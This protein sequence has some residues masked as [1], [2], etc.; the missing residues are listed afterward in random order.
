[1]N[2]IAHTTHMTVGDPYTVQHI[3]ESATP[4]KALICRP[5]GLLDCM[6]VEHDGIQYAGSVDLPVG[7]RLI[8]HEDFR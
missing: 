2:N 8:I 3:V 6:I 4:F 5:S 7:S 1:M